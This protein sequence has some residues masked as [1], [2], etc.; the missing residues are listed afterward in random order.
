MKRVIFMAVLF[1][2][3]ISHTVMGEPVLRIEFD[4]SDEG[5]VSGFMAIVSEGRPLPKNEGDLMVMIQDSDGN[6]LW[7]SGYDLD[8]YIYDAAIIAD[9]IR[10]SDKIP[11]LPEMEKAT[12]LYN[13][14][15]VFTSGLGLCNTNGLCEGNENYLSCPKDCPLNEKD[16][17]CIN[18]ADGVCDPDCLPGYDPDCIVT[19]MH[20]CGD[21]ICDVEAGENFASC[22]E[23][24]SGAA[25][26][27]CDRQKDG[28]C[29]PDCEE[30][31]DVDCRVQ[32]EANPFVIPVVILVIVIIIL[33][34]FL[35]S[36]RKGKTAQIQRQYNP[37]GGNQY[38]Y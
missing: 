21:G 20:S 7:Y 25:D 6:V 34:A 8:F 23:D 28:I 2:L 12:V 29:D 3:L 4:I 1:G 30:R 13:G 10:Y 19:G 11:Y 35:M 31:Y 22:P 17:I 26:G 38:D 37:Q 16:G 36:Y 15:V 9:E 18:K 14:A 27:I 24:C 32:E 5:N 33:V